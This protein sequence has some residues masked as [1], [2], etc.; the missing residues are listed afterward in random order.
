MDVDSLIK[1]LRT[2]PAEERRALALELASEGGKEA[3]SELIRMTEG[4][5]RRG[6][7]RYNFGDQLI[8]VEAL[9]ETGDKTALDYLTRIYNTTKKFTKSEDTLIYCGGSEPSGDI[10]GKEDTEIYIYPF[11]RRRLATKLEYREITTDT[12][13]SRFTG[14]REKNVQRYE[15]AHQT[16]TKAIENLR[17]YL[18]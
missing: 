8:G 18:N 6:L 3:V 5:I 11:A 17:T 12:I 4:R 2:C 10:Y 14:K 7:R 15:K 13:R 9:G 1:K 16:F